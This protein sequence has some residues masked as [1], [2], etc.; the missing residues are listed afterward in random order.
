MCIRD[1]AYS[2]AVIVHF[3]PTAISL[4]DLVLIHLHTHSCTST[5]P[6]RAKYRSAVYYFQDSGR[7]LIEDNLRKAQAEF[8]QPIITQALP[9]SAFKLNEET[10]QQYYLKHPEGQFCKT[11]IDPKIDLLESRY[12]RLLERKG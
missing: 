1:R 12:G 11:Y 8:D 7:A 9:F 6:M 2:E 10:Y 5:H 3:D 4:A